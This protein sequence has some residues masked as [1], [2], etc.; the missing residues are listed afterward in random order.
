MRPAAAILLAIATAAALHRNAA[1][2][3][4]SIVGSP[5]DLSVGGP[6]PIRAA[7]E[8]QVCIFCHTPHNASPIAALWNRSLSPQAYLVYTSKALDSRPAQPTGSSKL[9]LS[10][11]DGTIALG[12]VLSRPSPIQMSG[13]V[14]TMPAGPGNLGTD[15]RDDH[16]VSFRYDSGLASL[17]GKLRDPALLP[18]EFKLDANREL[19]CTTCHD[20]HNNAFSPFL[21]RR[22]TSSELCTSCHQMGTTDVVGHADCS[23][24][25]QPH[26]APSGP[27]L[28]RRRTIS[29]TC[30][31]CHDGSVP[32]AGAI[33]TDMHK[34]AS[35]DNDPSVDPTGDPTLALSC[36]SCHEPH[37]M[38]R[39]VG[40]TPPST[41]GPRRTGFERLGRIAGVS[42][43]G[44]PLAAASAEHQVC[45]T[46]HG[47]KNPITP[48]IPRRQPQA[49][50][51]RQFSPSAFSSHP[52]GAPGRA[53]DVPSLLP[54][55]T[56]A[57][58]MECSD[59]HASDSGLTAGAHGSNNPGLLV[60]RL[61]TADHTSESASAYGLCYRCHDRGSILDDRS[62]S[63]H[64]KH[65]VE[66]RTPCTACHDSH[67]IGSGTPAGNAHLI[68]FDTT[69]VFPELTTG[70]LEYRSTGARTGEC[71]LSCH[72]A[73][74]TPAR[75]VPR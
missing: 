34:A 38:R 52:V 27:Y 73:N 37:T 72:G 70:R 20:A 75:Y 17:N 66:H 29:Q 62:F 28:L 49:G 68:N 39:A 69:I 58:V 47:D 43:A 55:W 60:A 11:H 19:Q 6:G 74:H 12:A 1:A 5:H 31:A 15:L 23:S 56:T 2:Q 45:M 42:L 59:C 8:D 9:C 3:M 67:G 33:S 22:N 10:C 53:S 40:A 48:A 18:H 32:S 4:T 54:G 41:L 36:A 25:H 46:C 13:G 21:V 64:R 26:A 57:T 35:H 50:M 63:Q 16:P 14:T 65:I 44:A 61:T 24:C 71:F 7:V 30:N 51:R